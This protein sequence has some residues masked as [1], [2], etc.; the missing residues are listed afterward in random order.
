MS[1]MKAI[2]FTCE[3][4]TL[5][6]IILNKYAENRDGLDS[7][8][9]QFAR[10][11]YLTKP[12]LTDDKLRELLCEY[13]QKENL[14]KITFENPEEEAERI[15]QCIYESETYKELLF[16]FNRRGYGRTGLGVID[17]SDRSFYDCETAEHWDKLLEILE[18]KYPKYREALTFLSMYESLDEHNGMSRKDVDAFILETFDFVGGYQP[19]EEWL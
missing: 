2:P 9:V 7:K 11:E 4:L 18:K 1:N 17:L 19:L 8:A 14:S 6:R 13:A 5:V 3:P 12:T 15:F 10:Y 16:D